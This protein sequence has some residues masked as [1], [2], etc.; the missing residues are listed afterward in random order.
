MSQ[1]M[2]P[3]APRVGFVSLGCPK[4]L[5]D[6][7][8]ILTELR[9]EGYQVVPRYDD[10]EL[11]IVNTCGFID[12]AVQESLEAIGEAL[13]ENGKV[14]VTGCLGAKENQIREVHPKVL[15]ITGPH[16]YEQVLS[17]V[18]Q[19]VPKPEHN[20]FTSLTPAQG[21]KLTPK[22]Y[23]Y[24]KISEGCNH[25]CTFCIIPSMRGDL[26]S[27]PI[28]SV[29]DEAKRLVES[30]VKE[31]LVISQDTSAY[32]VDVKHRTGFWNGQPVKTSMVSLCE[33]LSSLGAWVRLHYVYP[34]PHVDDVIPLMAEG[35]ILPYLDIPLQHA[36]PKILKLMKRPGAVERTLE[37]IKRWR[38][39]C[40]ELTLRSTFIVGFPG[41]T[42]EDFQM[43][44]DFL[45]EAKLDRV[46]CFKFSPV[47]GAA[48]NELADP[49]PEEV[50]EERFHRFMQL[51]QQISA[52]RLQDK[53]G[54][55]VLVLIDE[56]DEEGAIGRSMADAP[57]IDG[58]VYLNGEANVKVGDIVKVKI[59]NADEYD[60]WGSKV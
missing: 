56:V 26:D 19:Y 5:V 8:R 55:E 37:R 28:G 54:R 48:A 7:E 23:A 15:E 27:R 34:Y 2:T 35:K 49:V 9:N 6:S 25:R 46:G 52:Q 24:L 53:I 47:E 17:H 57:E 11:V 22:H 59:E 43:L 42:E 45:A 29:L 36:S 60:L 38:E 21:V 30:G 31:L 40:P 16:S 20:P 18:H 33:Q 1:T 13:N 44:L 39:I 12:S 50:K 41:E 58:A 14:I 3:K 10:A 51:Q 32:G 4:N